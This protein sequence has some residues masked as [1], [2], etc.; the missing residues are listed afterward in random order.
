MSTTVPKLA[1]DLARDVQTLAAMAS[2]LTPY[3]YEE[4]VFGYLSGDLPRLTLGGVLLRLYR[5]SRMEA[6][7]NDEQ[8]TVVRDAQIN[9]EAERARW[10]VHY[11]QKL[12][13]ELG[14]RLNALEQFLADCARE[15]VCGSEYPMQAEKRTMIA[16]LYDEAAEHDILSDEVST[17]LNQLD[18]TLQRLT[19]PGPFVYTDERLAAVYPQARFWWLYAHIPESDRA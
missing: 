10:A 14:M 9:F 8:R 5:L 2:N 19:Q 15:L 13:R 6:Y 4:E 12:Q 7:L 1:Y 18:A 16:H 11:E 3:M 17:R